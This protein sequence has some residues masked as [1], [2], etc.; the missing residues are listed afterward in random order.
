[1]IV[2][3]M[4]EGQLQVGDSVA[5]E[6]NSLDDRLDAAVQQ[7]DEQAFHAALDALLDRVRAVG[8]PLPAGSLQSSDLIVPR[9]DATMDEVKELLAGGGL[10]PG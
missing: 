4:G 1:V 2:R 3:I 8:S 5:A 6:L 9:A 10:I 7:G